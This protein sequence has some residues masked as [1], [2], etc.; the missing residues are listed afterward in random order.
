MNK[1]KKTWK[2][3]MPSRV[4]LYYVDYDDNLEYRQHTIQECINENSDSPLME[5]IET[6]WDCPEDSYLK[7]IKSKME[8]D[9]LL[10]EYD[11]HYEDICDYLY[12][13]DESTPIKDLM[14]N[15][16]INCFYDLG[17]EVD[18]I[19]EGFLTTPYRTKTIDEELAKCRTILNISKG[20]KQEEQL[21][22]IIESCSYGGNLRIYFPFEYDD[23]VNGKDA[24]D[25]YKTISFK[26]KFTVAVLNSQEGNGD[27]E[28]IDLDCTFPFK[29]E[30]IGLSSLDHYSMENTCGLDY[31]WCK[32]DGQYSFG[33]DNTVKSTDIKESVSKK[34]R[35][36]QAQYE[37]TF[38]EGGCTNGDTDIRRHRDI[39]YDNN[40]PCE[41]RCP[42]CGQFWID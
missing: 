16:H 22:G 18:G 1:T 21:K 35:A 14:R 37:K 34:E 39:Y 28:D 36:L 8:A 41:I 23:F 33:Y 7:D 29:R 13:H 17:Y 31:N 20:S 24:K 30:N 3:Y 42:H 38:K 32:T 2:D 11:K 9:G 6:C 15:T 10:D 40:I 4:D 25:D 12:E 5:C 27:F 19:H 26:G